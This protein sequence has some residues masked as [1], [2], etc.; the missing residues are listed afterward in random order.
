VKKNNLLQIAITT[1]L[2]ANS[3][4]AMAATDYPAADFEPKVLYQD[5]SIKTTAPA[6]APA[7]KS[8][9]AT[10]ST[11]APAAEE[12]YDARYPA[13][14]FEPK[15]LYSDETYKHT[16]SA[17][18]V[19]AVASES[20]SV[21]VGQVEKEDDSNLLLLGLLAAAAVGG[22]VLTK[23]GAKTSGNL[24]Q[25]HVYA[26]KETGVARYLNARIPK[27][28]GVSKYLE[29]NTVPTNVARYIARQNIAHK[30]S[31]HNDTDRG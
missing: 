15:V 14:N 22:F 21:S 7:A 24:D 4:V 13:T 25:N 2:M 19:Y 6:T 8:S 3:F 26:S 23:G 12:A 27:V 30:S 31:A 29:R 10:A 1:L 11:S 5:A 16:K 28:S 17:P 18:A 9:P 20:G